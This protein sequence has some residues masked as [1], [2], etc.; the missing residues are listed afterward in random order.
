[1][2]SGGEDRRYLH[3]TYTYTYKKF[4]LFLQFLFCWLSYLFLLP[5]TGAWVCGLSLSDS[6]QVDTRRTGHNILQYKNLHITWAFEQKEENPYRFQ[7]SKKD[8]KMHSWNL[9][10]VFVIH[11]SPS[12]RF[13]STQPTF[14]YWQNF[15]PCL[16]P[17]LGDYQ[18]IPSDESQPRQRPRGGRQYFRKPLY[19]EVIKTT[20]MRYV[21]LISCIIWQVLVMVDYEI[22]KRL[23][24][25]QA[26]EQY[27]RQFINSVNFRWKKENDSKKVLIIL[28]QV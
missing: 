8:Y 17:G 11:P 27:A 4:S 9:R 7:L 20:K 25:V 14:V 16:D 19:P 24:S 21:D 2:G 10:K 23:G 5:Q 15:D 13:E 1:M 22:Y 28:F 12:L 26:A 6:G 3:Y 18:E